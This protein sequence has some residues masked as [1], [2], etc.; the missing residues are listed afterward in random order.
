M[1]IDAPVCVWVPRIPLLQ[2]SRA[3]NAH[4]FLLC[5]SPGGVAAAD[6]QMVA[7]SLHFPIHPCWLM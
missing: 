4:S 6:A 1:Y 5:A 7:G 2:G 3:L